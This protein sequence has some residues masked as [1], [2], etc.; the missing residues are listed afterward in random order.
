MPANFYTD[1]DGHGT[2]VCG[3]AAGKTY[4]WAKESDIYVMNILGVNSHSTIPISQSF[5]LTRIW[6]TQ[7]VP[8]DT[9]YVRPTVMNM[10]WA[11]GISVT[12]V[13][14]GNYRGTNWTGSA[15][16]NAYGV[17]DNGFGRMPVVVD[18]VQADIEDCLDAGVILIA[19]AGNTSYK[20]D[21]LG[22]PDYNNYV[23]Y[24]GFGSTPYYYMRGA[25]PQA[26][27]RVVNVGA[28]A[29]QTSPERKTFFSSA[30]PG[31][32]FYT[33]GDYVVGPC[34]TTEILSPSYP[35]AT[36]P[37]NSSYKV[38]KVSGTSQ[39]SPSVAGL[40]C[41]LLQSRPWYDIDRIINFFNNNSISNRLQDPG[42][43]TSYTDFE[44]LLGGPNKYV[45][46]TFTGTQPTVT[47][48]LDAIIHG[49]L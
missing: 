3:I 15:P 41:C 25:T 23:L 17:I 11:Y 45:Y 31:V 6:H 44:S 13:V 14:G 40:V 1:A 8:A 37:F 18:S 46:N 16:Q 42:S 48:N 21:I 22:G 7:K 27:T 49:K 30:G 10:S 35:V 29:L 12:A 32:P 9:G 5:N 26:S 39:A 2:N 38:A 28:V 34:S 47:Q 36:Y 4:G 20:I 43:S 24:N 19:A 33:A